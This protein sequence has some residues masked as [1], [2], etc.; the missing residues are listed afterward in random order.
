MYVLHGTKECREEVRVLVQ[1]I[2]RLY[3]QQLS[4]TVTIYK[5]YSAVIIF[6]WKLYLETTSKA[7]SHDSC[8][9][10]FGTILQY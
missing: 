4:V 6:L 9:I 1:H 8:N 2:K 7:S 10:R 5:N 3:E